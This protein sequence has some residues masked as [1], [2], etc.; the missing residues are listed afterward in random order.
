M[1][2]GEKIQAI[3]NHYGMGNQLLILAEECSELTKAA[4]KMIRYPD[5]EESRR[6]LLE[7][8]ADVEIMLRQIE[9][10]LSVQDAAVIGTFIRAKLDRQLKKV[11]EENG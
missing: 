5:R 11:E 10:F 7:E 4:L 8:M 2:T 3:A 9:Y 6:N 1:T